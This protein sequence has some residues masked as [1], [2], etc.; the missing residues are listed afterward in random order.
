[1]TASGRAAARRFIPALRRSRA[2]ATRA[3]QR[4]F[5]WPRQRRKPNAGAAAFAS[6]PPPPP[7][8][9]AGPGATSAAMSAASMGS[10]P[11]PHSGSS[12]LA[13]AAASRGQAAYS[14]M[15][16]ARFSLSGASTCTL[17][18]R[19]PRRCRLWPLRS[20]EMVT[21]VLARCAFTR[22]SGARASTEGRAP[23]AARNW[24]T[25]ASLMRTAPKRVSRMRSLTPV[26][27]TARVSPAPR[28]SLQSTRLRRG[29]QLVAVGRL[30]AGQRQQDAS[31]DPRPQAGA[32]RGLERAG[33][34]DAGADL[35][36]VRRAEA[37][38]LAGQ[39]RL[40]A[41]RDG[42]EEGEV[43]HHARLPRGRPRPA[44]AGDA[45]AGRRRRPAANVTAC[46]V[47]G[48]LR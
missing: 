19:Y 30:P 23:L 13:P 1:M 2:S 17:S 37:A 26:K 31:A 7:P 39:Q 29:V 18:A 9:A 36:H 40:E 3:S 35:L 47:R 41:A 16:A 44:V 34:G 28:C 14:S 12:K 42:G 38:Q 33:E 20:I 25:I 22:T 48:R 27:S 46:G 4:T 45:A 15:P 8:R 11:D 32:V 43:G 5:W 21:R 10:V 24:S 6:L